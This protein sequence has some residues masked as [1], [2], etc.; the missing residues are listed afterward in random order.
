VGEISWNIYDR[1]MMDICILTFVN[2]QH[3]DTSNTMWIWDDM[4]GS[5]SAAFNTALA[6]SEAADRYKHQK[7]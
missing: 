5:E 2:I 4:G 1:Y 6:P 3:Y 7:N